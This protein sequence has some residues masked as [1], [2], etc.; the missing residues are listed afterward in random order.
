MDTIEAIHGRRSIRV[1]RNAP[2]ERALIED[3]LFDAA[4]APTPPVSGDTPWA[5][6]VIE[7]VERIARY[8]QRARDYARAHRPPD[9][10]W[11]WTD[12]PAFKVFWDAPAL[13]LICGS[14][15]NPEAVSDCCRAAQNLMLSAHAR[16]LGTCW[17][18]APLPWL[19]SPG[20][21]EELGVPHA[22]DPLVA[23]VLGHPAESPPGRPRPRPAIRWG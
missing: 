12:D 13:V 22:F 11:R 4:Q 16:G 19:A 10:P 5:F 15:A 8:G 14:R 17:V 7:G 1:Y 3:V 9:R 23:M 21:A 18:G 20:I 2:V 6:C